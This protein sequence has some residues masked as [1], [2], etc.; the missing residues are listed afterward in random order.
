MKTVKIVKDILVYGSYYPGPIE[1]FTG[2]RWSVGAT[3]EIG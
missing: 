3:F 2:R 1:N